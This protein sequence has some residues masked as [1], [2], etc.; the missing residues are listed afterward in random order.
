M[1]WLS[2]KV[3]SQTVKILSMVQEHWNFLNEKRMLYMLFMFSSFY[4]GEC[5]VKHIWT[6]LPD[7]ILQEKYS[8][9]TEAC[10]ILYKNLPLYASCKA[11]IC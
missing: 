6:V 11:G 1:L 10:S 8:G 7:N 9:I 2:G 4:K 3:S 5:V